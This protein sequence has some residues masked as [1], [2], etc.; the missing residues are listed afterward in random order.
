MSA[1]YTIYL[2]DLPL[3]TTELEKADPPM[4]VVAGIIH[5]SD[6]SYGFDFLRA[7][8]EE[9]LV[10]HSVLDEGE[11]CLAISPIEQLVVRNHLGQEIP[12]AGNAIEGMEHEG[13]E[14]TL[15]G[16]PYPFYGEEFPHHVQ[17]YEQAYE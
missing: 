13:F 10:A 16:V 9:N 2:K 6:P 8:C 1:P 12:A 3:G 11:K 14:L 15:L 4:G 17:A 5:F 7:Y